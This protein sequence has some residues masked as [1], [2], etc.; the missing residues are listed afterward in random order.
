MVKVYILHIRNID[1]IVDLFGIY[2]SQKGTVYSQKQIVLL[3]MI[4]N[5]ARQSLRSVSYIYSEKPQQFVERQGLF[6]N[7]DVIFSSNC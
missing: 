2:K 3:A 1:N 7:C 6:S 4:T 5:L